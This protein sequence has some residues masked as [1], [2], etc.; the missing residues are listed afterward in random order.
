M[1]GRPD[2]AHGPDGV[3]RCAWVGSD[4]LQIAYH[5]TEWGWSVNGEAAWFERLSLEA[6]QSGLSWATVLRK[7]DGFRRAFA[8]FDPELVAAFTARDRERL[9]ADAGIIRNAA[10]IAATI[11]NARAVLDLREA[12]GLEALVRA[13]RPERHTRPSSLAEVPATSPESHALARALKRRGFVFVGP[14]TMYA[15]MQACGIVDDH[16]VGCHRAEAG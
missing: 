4:P 6:F 13:H 10:K 12:G 16:V 1:S 2:L 7:R 14:T 3:A 8:G 9:M 15:A 11:G 5:D